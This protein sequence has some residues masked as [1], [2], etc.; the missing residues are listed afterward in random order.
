MCFS[1]MFWV[2]SGYF[3]ALN[4]DC[5][6]YLKIPY[7]IKEIQIISLNFTF[8]RLKGYFAKNGL[9]K[10]L[11]SN[12]SVKYSCNSIWQVWKEIKQQTCFFPEKKSET[13]QIKSPK[14]KKKS[15]T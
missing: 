6:N 5:E 13:P 3:K 2:V 9:P 14:H 10:I 7:K 4:G 1:R 12:L 15:E 8:A 11:E